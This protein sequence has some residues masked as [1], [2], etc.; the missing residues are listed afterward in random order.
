MFPTPFDIIQKG[1]L[2]V[3]ALFVVFIAGMGIGFIG[4]IIVGNTAIGD[5]LLD[6]LQTYQAA[7]DEELGYQ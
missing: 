1:F 5:T 7:M 6:M 4:G 2:M 3:A